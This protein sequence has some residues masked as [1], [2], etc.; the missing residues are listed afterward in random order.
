[1]NLFSKQMGFVKPIAS[2]ENRGA[3]KRLQE[4]QISVNNSTE[5]KGSYYSVYFGDW[6]KLDKFLYCSI[7]SKDDKCY[8]AFHSNESIEYN[9]K[10]RHEKNH[11][12]NFKTKIYNKIVVQFIVNFLKKN[13]KENLNVKI[14][15][16]KYHESDELI[17]FT[18]SNN[19]KTNILDILNQ[20]NK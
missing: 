18:F 11:K 8:L 1:M 7:A 16:E 9:A 3:N 5:K 17:V 14:D 13:P 10:V 20:T 12:G 2:Q 4:N 15:L 6:A 19:K